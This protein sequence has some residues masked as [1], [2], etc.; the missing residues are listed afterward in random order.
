MSYV[1]AFVSV[2]RLEF[3][4]GGV[5]FLFVVSAL[6]SEYWARLWDNAVLIIWGTVVWYLSHAIGSQ[7]NCLA[8][9]ELDRQYKLR[10]AQAVDYLGRRVIWGLVLVESFLALL[11]TLHMVGLTGKPLLTV[12]WI[13]GWLVT[14]GY[15]LEPIRF[16][17][18]GF[19]NPISLL[20]V[21]YILPI[22]YGYVA[23][24][25]TGNIMV[26]ILLAAIGLQMLSLILM[27]EVED[28]AEDEAHNIET[29]CVRY[30]LWHVVAVAL[31]L[32]I[33]GAIVT[34]YIFYRLVDSGSFQL[35]LVLLGGLGQL[36]II[37]DLVS[38]A[39]ISRRETISTNCQGTELKE[40]RYLG[41]RNAVHFAILGLTVSLGSVLSLQ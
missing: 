23:L 29:P 21:L 27:N 40:V 31:P 12:L 17:R 7:V 1:R 8:D 39:A 25:N 30:G 35:I 16:K 19:L 3:A 34:T 15:S 24:K 9:Y 14:L 26:I 28:I 36:F 2:N 38:L 22:T 11:V 37:R 5:F 33:V 4:P 18:R 32:F 41:R 6:A 13:I 20:L 10:L